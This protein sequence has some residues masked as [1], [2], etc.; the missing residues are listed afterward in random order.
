MNHFYE[1]C[2]LF[3]PTNLPSSSL[4]LQTMNTLIMSHLFPSD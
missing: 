4:I 2:E 3:Q 1:I